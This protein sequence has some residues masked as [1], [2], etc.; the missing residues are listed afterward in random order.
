MDQRQDFLLRLRPL[1]SGIPPETRLKHAL[2]LLLRTCELKCIMIE[3]IRPP[4]EPSETE[5]VKPS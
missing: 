4:D 2:K 3:E 5:E 1:P